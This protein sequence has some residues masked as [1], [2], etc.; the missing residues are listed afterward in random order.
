MHTWSSILLPL[1]VAT[2]LV[3]VP[4]ATIAIASGRRGIDAI[5]VS[6]ALSTTAIALTAIAGGASPWSWGLWMTA[7]ATAAVCALVLLARRWLAYAAAGRDRVRPA[8]TGTGTGSTAAPARLRWASWGNLWPLVGALVGLV[9]WA[10][11]LHR[12]LPAPAAISQT[13]DNLFHLSAVRFIMDRGDASSL[14]LGALNAGP[15]ASAFYPGAWH[16][17]VSLVAETTGAPVAEATLAMTCATVG[18]WVLACQFLARCVAPTSPLTGALTGVLSASFGA[19]PGFGLSWGIL[20]PN[21][22]GVAILPILIGLGVQTLG[23]APVRLMAA[24]TAI[25]VAPGLALA[26]PNTI[27]TAVVFATAAVAVR[28]VLTVRDAWT[29]RTALRRAAGALLGGALWLVV[30]GVLWQR[31]RPPASQFVWGPVMSQSEAIGKLILNSPLDLWPAW[32]VSMLVAMGAYRCFRRRENLWLPL[33][34]VLLGYGWVIIASE[35]VGAWRNLVTGPWYTDFYRIA[36]VLPLV[37]LPLALLGG[38][39]AVE[40]LTPRRW[41]RGTAVLG[42][43]VLSVTALV[44]CTQRTEYLE[45]ATAKVA[46][47]YTE[48]PRA[49]LLDTDERALLDRLPSEVPPGAV[50]AT[51]PWNG[52]SLAYALEGIPTTNHHAFGYVSPDADLLRMSLADAETDPRVCPTVTRLGVRYVLVFAGPNILDAPNTYPGI[53]RVDGAPGFELVDREGEARLFRVTACGLSS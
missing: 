36:M 29:R 14:T 27:M 51:D 43:T 6:P 4:G 12:I 8:R 42:V 15:G 21:F 31:L 49:R 10:R 39:Q 32:A 35:P 3:V 53:A 26:H 52:S 22:L 30:A 45:R 23:V 46:T 41:L 34:W 16:G 40:L 11:W 47:T 25:A 2:L 13:F 37:C 48:S 18:I 24:R 7:V 44:V 38:L 28:V 5:L 33:A 20:S 9:L 50:V 1:T 17:Y 19:F